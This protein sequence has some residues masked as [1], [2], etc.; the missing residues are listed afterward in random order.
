[1]KL[2][3][4]NN[5]DVRNMSNFDVLPAFIRFYRITERLAKMARTLEQHALQKVS[6]PLKL[7]VPLLAISLLSVYAYASSVS[8]TSVPSESESGVLF[9]VDDSFT[10]TNNGFFIAQ[11][12]SSASAQPFQWSNGAICQTALVAGDWFYSLTLN[13]TVG[14]HANYT[15]TI[16]VMWNIGSGYNPLVF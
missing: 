1:L 10:V 13:M 11:G 14:A 3:D 4:V 2:S 5:Y 15:Y 16:T 7:L 12:T 9:N 6:L 8:V